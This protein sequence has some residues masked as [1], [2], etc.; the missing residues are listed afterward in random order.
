MKKVDSIENLR[1]ALDLQIDRKSTYRST[2]QKV[3]P[4]LNTLID[5]P[6]ITDED[7]QRLFLISMIIMKIARYSKNICSGGHKDSSIDLINYSSMLDAFTD[8]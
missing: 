1:K 3:G 8:E 5:S 4:I 7:Y 6:P 2:Y